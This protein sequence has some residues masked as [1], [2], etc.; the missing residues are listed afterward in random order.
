MDAKDAAVVVFV[1]TPLGILLVKDPT[2]LPPLYWKL[3]GGKADLKEVDGKFVCDETPAEIARREVSEETG[4]CA[5]PENFTILIAEDRGDHQ[6][7]L[8]N[9]KVKSL[10]GLKSRGDEGEAVR[11]LSLEKLRNLPDFMPSHRRLMKKAGIP[12]A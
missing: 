7:Y 9:L 6:L 11:I 4:I 8:L 12:F 3:P 2:K 5:P 10:E 1:E